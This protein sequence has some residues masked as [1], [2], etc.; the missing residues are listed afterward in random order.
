MTRSF[1]RRALVARIR[2]VVNR[3]G[4][5]IT[6][7]PFDYRLVKLMRARG[8]TNVLDIGA[9]TGQFAH[10]LRRAGFTGR[11]VS[12]EPLADAFAELDRAAAAD[13]RW[14]AVR[15][16]VSDEAGPITINVASNSVSSSALPMLARHEQAAPESAYVR[17]E[18]VAATTVDELVRTHGLEPARTLLKVDVQGFEDAVLRGAADSLP[19]FGA[20]QLELSVAALY[21]GQL[22]MSELVQQLDRAGLELWY[23]E[24][25]FVDETSGRVLQYDGTFFAR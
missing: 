21:G 18:R 22:L 1:A 15:A 13:E 5:D 20:A 14:T 3:A 6:R 16:A 19:V 7:E 11:I 17:T 2:H 4:F 25:A 24:P 10:V 9:N 8:V 23:L 12:V